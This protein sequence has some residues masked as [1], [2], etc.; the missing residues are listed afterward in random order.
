MWIWRHV[1]L[2]KLSKEQVKALN[3]LLDSDFSEG[4]SNP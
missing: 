2:A 3:W 4:L 1:D